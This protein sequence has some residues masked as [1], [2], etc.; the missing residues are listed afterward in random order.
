MRILCGAESSE[1]GLRDDKAGPIA[2]I[3]ERTSP[4]SV[5][6]YCLGDL[7]AFVEQVEQLGPLATDEQRRIADAARASGADPDFTECPSWRAEWE[8]THA[9]KLVDL[10]NTRRRVLGGARAA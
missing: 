10:P 4:A 6:G 9:R 2:L 8:N 1:R 3:R 5:H 7:P